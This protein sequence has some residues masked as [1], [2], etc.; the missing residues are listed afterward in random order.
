MALSPIKCYVRNH[1]PQTISSN[2]EKAVQIKTAL[3]SLGHSLAVC[4]SSA[5]GLLHGELLAVPGA[6]AYCH[7]GAVAYSE[8]SRR[9]LLGIPSE[10]A[11]DH[12]VVSE[13]FALLL[14]RTIRERLGTVWG[15]AESG[16]AG[17]QTNRRSRK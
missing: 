7:G 12:G 4:E 3:T 15:L 1:H 16:I 9:A 13:A 17:P 2:S 6:S 8:S 10:A 5:G 14:A 11:R